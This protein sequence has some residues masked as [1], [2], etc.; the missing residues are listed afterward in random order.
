MVSA[1]GAAAFRFIK[2]LFQRSSAAWKKKSTIYRS[3]NMKKS[4]TPDCKNGFSSN[5]EPTLSGKAISSVLSVTYD[6]TIGT[7]TG[8]AVL[9]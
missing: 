6:L 9:A 4:N 1:V 7:M 3:K 8:M 2:N 5:T